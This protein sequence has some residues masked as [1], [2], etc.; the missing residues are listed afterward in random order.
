MSK[1][2]SDQLIS[3]LSLAVES[4]LGLHY[5][6]SR[7]DDVVR[8]LRKA[9]ADLGFNDLRSCA[10]WLLESPW[11]EPRIET[12][13]G[14][15]TVGETH[16]FRDERLFSVLE[17][18]IFPDLIR[19]RCDSGRRLKIWSAG[20]AT[21]EEPYSLAILLSRL[22]LDL[23]QWQLTILATDVNR[24]FLRKARRGVYG[25]W[26]FRSVSEEIKAAYFNTN[27]EGSEIDARIKKMVS[28]AFLNL[29]KE[30]LEL[31]GGERGPMDVIFC[32]NVLMYFSAEVQERAVENVCRFLAD[33]GWLIVSPAEA[34]IICHP[35]LVQVTCPGAILFRK[36]EAGQGQRKTFAFSSFDPM[37]EP[38]AESIVP[39]FL[40]FPIF[41]PDEPVVPPIA[42]PVLP[43][44][45]PPPAQ[46]GPPPKE[47][48]H[49]AEAVALH[50]Q[51][52]YEE[53]VDRLLP[54]LECNRLSSDRVG[55]AMSLLA[56]AYANQGKLEDALEW[57]NKTI[58]KEKLNPTYHYLHG[59]ILHEQGMLEEAAASLR[60]AVFLDPD[61]AVAHFALGNLARR[62]GKHK[63]SA[64]HHRTA[65][66]I[67]RRRPPDEPVE[68]SDGLTA[69]RLSE[70]IVALTGKE[71]KHD[72]T[73][74]G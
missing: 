9:A 34:P 68:A 40:E 30:I 46:V 48:D 3:N 37:P 50:E 24:S 12:L 73:R 58:M 8:A 6:P 31:P 13:A 49:Y 36:D 26:S 17:H 33:G 43:K 74:S 16:F 63:E 69:G 66:S 71:A 2:L 35:A 38:P 28:F 20:C 27:G 44:E 60:R 51:G 4:H 10:E 18:D 55:S 72:R 57:S 56:R 42:E 62:S 52:R 67:L 41:V 1:A 59:A 32:R 65:L 45:E 47:P 15:L 5:P 23:T 54:A 39:P 14:Y 21:G 53:V 25:Q 11:G 22:I 61:L 64:R 7:R 70:I 19:R 29:A